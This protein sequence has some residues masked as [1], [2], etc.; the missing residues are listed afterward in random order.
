MSDDPTTTLL[1][2]DAEQV[3]SREEL[4]AK[5]KAQRPLR[6]KLG[7]DPTAPDIHLGHAVALRKLRQFQELGHQV[8][9]IIGDFTAMI[10]DPSGRSL[11][12]PP[13]THEEVL[14]NAKTF[15][16]QAFLILD[17]DKTETVY[18]GD[19]F[20]KMP[21]QEVIKLNARVTMQQML[22]RE[23]FKTRLAE[24]H[25]VRLHEIQY[26]IMQG[27]DSVV[28]RADVEIG[29]TDQLFNILVGRDLQ[30]SQGMEPQVVLTLPLL[31]G[32]DGKKKM[33]KSLGNYVGLT[34]APADMFGKIMSISDELMP[35]YYRLV[36]GKDHDASQHPMEAKKSLAEQTV[37]LYHSTSI[38]REARTDFENKFGKGSVDEADLPLVP[39]PAPETQLIGFVADV[40][41]NTFQQK[42]SNGD[43]RRLVQQGSVQLNGEKLT[44]PRTAVTLNPGDVVKLDKKRMIRL[45]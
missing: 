22:Q 33:S 42:R 37:G 18:N 35:R 26:P 44:D 6:V 13:L 21:F 39:C 31:E 38:A 12:R 28:I 19:W 32:L 40:Y 7:V 45:Q 3:H 1:C 43:I 16:E 9:L 23:D 25:E 20:S 36:L 14:A 27:W 34:D 30:K 2:Q 8:V 41:A 11:T 15:T 5:L 4:T 10:G 29:G 24:G 17:E